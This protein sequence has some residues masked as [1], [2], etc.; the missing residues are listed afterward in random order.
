MAIVTPAVLAENPHNFREQIERVE[1]FA[2]RVH[3]DFMDGIFTPTKSLEIKQAWR[4]S[5][6]ETDMHVMY[7]NPAEFIDD[8]IAI[9]PNLVILHAEA[10]GNFIA[11]AERLRKHKIK[12][13]VAVLAE[14]PIDIIE[15]ALEYI[16]H[17]LI[18][19]GDLGRFG[20]TADLKL[21]DKAEWCKEMKPEVEVGWDGGANETN[22][23][24]IVAAG[25][26]VVTVGGYIQR[27]DNPKAAFE[28][29]QNLIN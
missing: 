25:V 18:F 10:E 5:N 23:Q 27:N 6:I 2:K 7:K 14:T 28:R 20:G 15:P 29:L 13:G 1:P 16:D 24:R 21:L 12:T 8:I 19:S 4:L 22:I 3:L 17:V 26:D 11:F 9:N